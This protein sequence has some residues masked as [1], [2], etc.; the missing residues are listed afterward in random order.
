MINNSLNNED[1]SMDVGR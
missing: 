1:N